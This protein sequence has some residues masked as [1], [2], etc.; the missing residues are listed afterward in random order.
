MYVQEDCAAH[1][2]DQKAAITRSLVSGCAAAEQQPRAHARGLAVKRVAGDGLRS[3][4]A[5][6]SSSEPLASQR[7]RMI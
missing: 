3:T 7:E 4:C 2:S 6:A 5:P 1:T